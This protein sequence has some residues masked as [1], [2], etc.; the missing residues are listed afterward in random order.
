MLPWIAAVVDLELRVFTALRQD[1]ILR[2]GA[3][4]LDFQVRSERFSLSSEER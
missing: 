3:D 1:K 4:A 2:L